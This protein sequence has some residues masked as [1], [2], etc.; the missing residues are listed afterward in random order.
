MG[1]A[2]SAALFVTFAGVMAGPA[3][4]GVLIQSGLAYGSAFVTMGLPALACGLLLTRQA[5][6]RG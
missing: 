3:L 6:L 2:T 5:G 4:F 1:T